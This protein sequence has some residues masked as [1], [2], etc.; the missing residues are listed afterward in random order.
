MP[1]DEYLNCPVCGM[2]VPAVIEG[3]EVK[4][5]PY[6]GEELDLANVV[7]NGLEDADGF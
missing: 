5:C 7:E 6:C 1:V 3:T 4:Y 2:D